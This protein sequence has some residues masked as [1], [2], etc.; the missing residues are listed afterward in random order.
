MKKGI[1]IF[2]TSLILMMTL[3]IENIY[4]AGFSVSRSTSSVSPGG[5]FTVSVS[6]QG[7]GQFSVSA[8]NGSVS[9][10]SLWVDGSGSV[11]V[12][13]GSSGTVTVSVSAIDVTGYDESSITGSRSVSVSINTPTSS[14]NSNSSQ[15]NSSSSSSNTTN[16]N[17]TTT[18][19]TNNQT[20][21]QQ[22]ETKK[23]NNNNLSSL[24]LSTG[25]LN[26]EFNSNQTNYE[27]NVDA[28]MTEI[29]IDAKALDSKASITGTGKH[30]LQVGS[31]TFEIKCKAENGSVKT[32]TITINVDE[33]PLVYL[34]H[35]KQKLGV[36]RNVK[37]L[38]IPES[39]EATT[40]KIDDQD[41]T[42]YHNN[43]MN[44]TILYLV[45][46]KG[47]KNFYLY[48]EKEGVTSI[49]T[50]VTLLGRNVYIIDV[51]KDD[52]KVSNTKYNKIQIDNNTLNGWTF[53][54]NKNYSLIMVMNAQGEKVIYQYEATENTLQLYHQVKQKQP[55]QQKNIMTYVFAATTVVFALISLVLIR[56][57][58][59]HK[60]H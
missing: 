36:V 43:N 46:E 21:Q 45:N 12:T 56:Y 8:S 11:T 1:K 59:I 33:T 9:S 32:Y 4:A 6:C 55:K 41:V 23:S 37:D 17:T 52:V 7:A 49:F 35:N 2:I 10:S 25:T 50:P 5:R 14:N 58:Y 29:T 54:D 3:S 24:T 16:N 19:E 60:K 31:N 18:N 47:E 15:T 40:I 39:F 26:P 20:T 34:K 13:A 42:A 38:G 28:K 22:E 27:V 48:D 57:F 53:K 44:K 30:S 51:N